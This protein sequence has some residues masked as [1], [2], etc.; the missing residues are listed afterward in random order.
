MSEYNGEIWG[1]LTAMRRE[2][3]ALKS[4]VQRL[5]AADLRSYLWRQHVHDI[6]K[7]EVCGEPHE[8]AVVPI[9]PRA[10]V[11]GAIGLREVCESCFIRTRERQQ[12]AA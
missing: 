12:V 1:E 2:L 10:A 6:G 4:Q 9:G 5:E 7:C 11:G 3:K 8:V